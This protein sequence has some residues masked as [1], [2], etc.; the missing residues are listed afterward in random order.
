LHAFKSWN[1]SEKI[2]NKKSFNKILF[3]RGRREGG[4]TLDVDEK[5]QE[6]QPL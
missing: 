2:S 1:T 5:A 3:L 4:G 6:S